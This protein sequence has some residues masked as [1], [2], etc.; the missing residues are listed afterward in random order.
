MDTPLDLALGRLSLEPQCSEEEHTPIAHRDDSGHKGSRR[1]KAKPSS[2]GNPAL[3]HET[4]AVGWPRH[5]RPIIIHMSRDLT[6]VEKASSL[7][8]DWQ[9]TNVQIGKAPQWLV[10][11]EFSVGST[12]SVLSLGGQAATSSAAAGTNVGGGGSGVAPGFP[13]E[14]PQEGLMLT[15][16]GTSIPD[17]K[18][19]GPSAGIGT[20]GSESLYELVDGFADRMA[21]IKRVI[22]FGQQQEFEEQERQRNK[23]QTEEQQQRGEQE[24]WHQTQQ[25]PDGSEVGYENRAPQGLERYNHLQYLPPGDFEAGLER[26]HQQQHE[27]GQENTQPQSYSGYD[28]EPQAAQGK[29]PELIGGG[30]LE[31]AVR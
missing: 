1:R 18:K 15:V 2:K 6:H 31:W 23:E 4:D 28:L 19:G 13:Q 9:L 14:Q 8:P 11:E 5:H 7:A 25:Y 22:E 27:V 10:G 21:M 3:E 26:R 24:Q 16:E 30:D 12:G 20:G 17:F 29:L